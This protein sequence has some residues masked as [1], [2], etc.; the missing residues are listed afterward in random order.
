MLHPSFNVY[1]MFAMGWGGGWEFAILGVV[2][3][4][5]NLKIKRQSFKNSYSDR[6]IAYYFLPLNF[7]NAS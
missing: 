6:L 2:C 3:L 7:V 4:P 1:R 5:L